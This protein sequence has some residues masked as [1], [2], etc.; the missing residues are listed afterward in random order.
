[1]PVVVTPNGIDIERFRPDPAERQVLRDQHDLG[2]DQCVALF[3]GGDWDRKGLALAVEAIAKSRADGADVVLW[4][5][6]DG[7]RARFASLA[8]ELG[9]GEAVTFFGPRADTERFYQ[10]ADLFVLPSAY[11]T[12]SLV[13]FEA[14]ACGLALVI[15]PLHGAGQL[16]GDD[17]AGLIVER[18]AADIA[19]AI[20]ELTADHDLRSRLGAEASLR[21]SAFSW[22]ASANAVT[23]LYRMLLEERSRR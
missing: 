1:M 10:A 21:A 6:G 9:V 4:V 20:V 16:V 12:F 19:R 7:D 23:D 2:A 8:E 14:A 11:E 3:L 5:V 17:E 22:D 18:D 13:C 15:P